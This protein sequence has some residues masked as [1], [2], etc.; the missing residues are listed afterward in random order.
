[1]ASQR[2]E[3]DHLQQA[4]RMRRVLRAQLVDSTRRQ[5]IGLDDPCAAIF[6]RRVLSHNQQM[7]HDFSPCCASHSG[8]ERKICFLGTG[9]G[10]RLQRVNPIDSRSTVQPC[11][12]RETSGENHA[13]FEYYLRRL[14][15]RHNGLGWTR[16]AKLRRTRKLEP[17][18]ECFQPDPDQGPSPAF[19]K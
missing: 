15:E 18:L 17:E 16:E 5:D 12:S 14:R 13:Q 6:V 11:S 1:V 8:P 2:P 4:R 7:R 3:H 19:R 10:I 9:H